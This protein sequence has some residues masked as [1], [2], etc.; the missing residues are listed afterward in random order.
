LKVELGDLIEKHNN[1]ATQHA[2]L[3]KRYG[4]METE[5]EALKEE[6]GQVVSALQQVDLLRRENEGLRGKAAT[7]EAKLR[8]L[9]NKIVD[10]ESNNQDLQEKT[11]TK[12]SPRDF[13]ETQKSNQQLETENAGL[14]RRLKDAQ[15]SLE[16]ARSSEK[17]LSRL[18]QRQEVKIA[19]METE[20]KK[21]DK[22][23][24]TW[25]RQ[26]RQSEDVLGEKKE[27][28][29]QLREVL[30]ATESESKELQAKVD[31]FASRHAAVNTQLEKLARENALLHYNLGVIYTEKALYEQAIKEYELAL[32]R[33]PGDPFAAYNL[34]IIYSQYVID[35]EQAV[36]YFQIYLKTAPEDK[37]ADRARRY[38]LTRGSYNVDTKI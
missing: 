8:N 10:L 16:E 29:D 22:E 7:S 25:V 32:E 4:E 21:W 18:A 27:K 11:R 19:R 12:V 2:E 33:N 5:W 26:E 15:R 13:R 6:Q 37:D 23:R 24:T 3:K 9:L 36:K 1:I 38:I 35:E 31:S 20:L 34:G 30:T 28:I 14:K 17:E